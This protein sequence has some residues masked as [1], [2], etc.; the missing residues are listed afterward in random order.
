MKKILLLILATAALCACKPASQ[1]QDE[2]TE[3]KTNLV[4]YFSATGTTEAVAQLLAQ[5]ANADLLEIE[6]KTPYTDADLD[7]RDSLSRSSVEMRDPASRPELKSEPTNLSHYD[8]IFVGFP[9]WWGVAPHIVNSFIEAADLKGKTVIPFA[10]S[11]SS[12]IEPAIDALRTAYPELDIADGRLLNNI[13]FEDLSSWIE[14]L[15]E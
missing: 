10:T 5:A 4:A 6:P 7:W 11:G 13:T 1:N 15:S 9:I 14:E 12:N 8:I 3:E 2:N